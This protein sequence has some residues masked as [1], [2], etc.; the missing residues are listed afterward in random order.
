MVDV[1]QAVGLSKKMEKE[2][3]GAQRT[4][5]VG[6]SAMV[7]LCAVREPPKLPTQQKSKSNTSGLVKQKEDGAQQTVDV[8]VSA[9]VD[10][11][12]V[13]EPLEPSSQQKSKS[14]T[15]K[16]KK[17]PS[18]IPPHELNAV[19]F[20][21][22]FPFVR[23]YKRMAQFPNIDRCGPNFS[24]QRDTLL[25]FHC[26]LA[27]SIVDSHRVFWTEGEELRTR[28]IH[29]D[30]LKQIG[31]LAYYLACTKK[32]GNTSDGMKVSVVEEQE[33]GDAPELEEEQ[34][35]L[36]SA[37]SSQ[38]DMQVGHEFSS[39][40]AGRPDFVVFAF[41]KEYSTREQLDR[42]DPEALCA[43]LIIDPKD[44]ALEK[45][46]KY[47]PRGVYQTAAYAVTHGL[48]N[49]KK[50]RKKPIVLQG[51]SKDRWSYGEF[52]V[53]GV[54]HVSDEGIVDD[55]SLQSLFDKRQNDLK[56]YMEDATTIYKGG[57]Y[58]AGSLF[59]SDEIL[60]F[61]SPERVRLP[62]DGSLRFL[63]A[64]LRI[65]L[66]ERVLHFTENDAKELFDA[67]R[68]G[69]TETEEFATSR[70]PSAEAYEGF[71]LMKRMRR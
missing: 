46:W 43:F 20:P 5:D 42:F 60:D 2:E 37:S 45:V 65:C 14:N 56:E 27:P 19:S 11:C 18:N 30:L 71:R 13:R 64:I 54:V 3:D 24:M 7:D 4:E 9:V 58:L 40:N 15:S 38:E 26:F 67:V 39:A 52:L 69:D 10:P 29:S 21:L 16:Q 59:I 8:G 63:E 17:H 22:K 1:G 68:A 6:V 41:D 62:S 51:W 47:G 57:K 61:L 49:L 34:L 33:E 28:P 23:V 70:F 12:A 35:E 50:G 66:G 36:Q 25:A 55:E 31:R 32:H 53:H 48:E 44:Y